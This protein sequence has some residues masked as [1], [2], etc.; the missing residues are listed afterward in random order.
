[1]SDRTPETPRDIAMETAPVED[2]ELPGDSNDI[3]EDDLNMADV[4]DTA[5]FFLEVDEAD[6]ALVDNNADGDA[7]DQDMMA[8]VDDDDDD[9]HEMVA[10]MNM[11]QTLGLKLRM[12]TDMHPR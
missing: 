4:G 2:P 11:L 5:D 10:L 6:D 12:L 8:L 1:M 7:D 9:D 3:G